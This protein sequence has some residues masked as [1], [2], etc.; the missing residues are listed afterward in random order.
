MNFSD[1]KVVYLAKAGFNSV[2][3]DDN[4][5]TFTNNSFAIL[6]DAQ[7]NRLGVVVESSKGFRVDLPKRK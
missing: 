6:R 3:P 5:S 1:A 4:R 7:G 2:V